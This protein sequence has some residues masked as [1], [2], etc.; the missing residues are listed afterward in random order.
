MVVEDVSDGAG[1]VASLLEVVGEGGTAEVEMAEGCA[2]V[3]VWEGVVLIVGEKGEMG[4]G[5]VE[6]VDVVDAEVDGGG[7]GGPG[8]DVAADEDGGL[9]GD[10]AEEGVLGSGVVDEEL[11]GAGVVR[12]VEEGEGL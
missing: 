12:E 1:D 3:V 4:G 7:G 5:G 2:D 9:G 8:D 11:C 10:G 6:E